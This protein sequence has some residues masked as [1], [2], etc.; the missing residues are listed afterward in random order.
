VV[1]KHSVDVAGN[2]E[3]AHAQGLNA[4]DALYFELALCRK[5]ALAT[6]D[7]GMIAAA[8]RAGIR[9]FPIPQAISA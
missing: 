2:P 9:L 4:R 7:A 5:D 8:L 1:D 6:H 3:C